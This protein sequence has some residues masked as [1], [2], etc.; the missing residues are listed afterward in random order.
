MPGDCRL[1][2]SNRKG[3][4]RSFTVRRCSEADLDEIMELQ[5]MVADLTGSDIFVE[6]TRE[7]MTESLS[8]D[9]CLGVYDADRLIAFG[10]MVCGRVTP[11]NLGT[12]LGYDDER[13]LQ[14][15]TYDTTFVHPDYRGYGLQ[16][17]L[18]QMRD[19]AAA[20][21]G[22][23]EALSSVSPENP[24]SLDNVLKRGF[25]IISE[26]ALYG[27]RRRYILRKEFW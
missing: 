12:Y 24:H 20:E 23:R 1:T 10:L 14:C 6:T 11:R 7:E 22:A 25:G 13:L 16:R 19:R 26:T 9:L 8:C 18:G 2:V 5:D 21:S 4:E 27:G 15:V 3:E 17:S